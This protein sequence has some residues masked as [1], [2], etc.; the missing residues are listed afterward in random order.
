MDRD[1]RANAKA[2][3]LRRKRKKDSKKKGKGRKD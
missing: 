1:W 3:K 2:W